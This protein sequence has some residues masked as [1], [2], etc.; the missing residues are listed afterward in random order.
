MSGSIVVRG[1]LE[2]GIRHLAKQLRRSCSGRHALRR[3]EI[4]KGGN[5][6]LLPPSSAMLTSSKPLIRSFVTCSVASWQMDRHYLMLS[7]SSSVRIRHSSMLAFSSAMS[8][9]SISSDCAA[10][11]TRGDGPCGA[12]LHL[13]K[14]SCKSEVVS[15]VVCLFSR[16]SLAVMLT[17]CLHDRFPCIFH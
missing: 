15:S 4:S 11:S 13:R 7:N 2:R 14:S 3:Y 17:C 5:N 9:D 6:D 1:L 12:S 10:V 8:D 16:R